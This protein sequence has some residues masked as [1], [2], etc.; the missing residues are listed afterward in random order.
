M[1]IR[2]ST[3]I[4]SIPKDFVYH[5]VLIREWLTQLKLVILSR[6]FG[7]DRV[8]SRLIF[9]AMSVAATY[10]LLQVHATAGA[11]Y[12]RCMLLQVHAT[13]GACYCRC[14]LLQV[15]A[16]AGACYCRCMLLQVHATAGACYCRYMLLQVHATAGACYCRCMLLQVH[17]TAGTCYCRYV[18]LQVHAPA[19]TCYCRCMLPH[20]GHVQ[21]LLNVLTSWNFSEI[22]TKMASNHVTYV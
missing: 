2:G 15:H 11:C 1:I 5:N 20:V 7:Q 6:L 10:M 8:H 14:M 17:A 12:C 9:L 19:G 4:F 21:N 3:P 22:V 16:T 13:A 18:L